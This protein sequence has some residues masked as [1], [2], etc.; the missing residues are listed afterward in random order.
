[1][2][3]GIRTHIA[4]GVLVVTAV[5]PVPA[6]A[7][8][9]A[10][11]AVG[12]APADHLPSPHRARP[13]TSLQGEARGEAP[14]DRRASR[15]GGGHHGRTGQ[16]L[17]LPGED[18]VLPGLPGGMPDLAD[19]WAALPD[20]ES[21]ASRPA[22]PR[23]GDQGTARPRRPSA[24]RPWG[25][26]GAGPGDSRDAEGPGA[27]GGRTGAGDGR[28]RDYGGYEGMWGEGDPFGL[29]YREWWA[30]YAPEELP[31]AGGGGPAAEESPAAS[32]V[33]SVRPSPPP[34]RAEK[35][36]PRVERQP[37]VQPSH[38]TPDRED[39]A[40]QAPR[41]PD[42]GATTAAQPYAE[43]STTARVE[44]VLPMGAGLTLTG[45]G[46]AFLGLRLRRR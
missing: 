29:R 32:A 24:D 4:T 7:A 17:R 28:G 37:P 13:F 11:P 41:V 43:E 21:S 40:R 6:G 36:G 22:S 46:L 38:R 35:T 18:A 10:S 31:E 25:P 33:P 42:D 26:P 45:L 44:R 27:D 12:A 14:P 20:H 39:L 30:S 8:L 3:P 9:A 1:M 2:A 15:G 23:D 34:R 16:L 5:L 19:L